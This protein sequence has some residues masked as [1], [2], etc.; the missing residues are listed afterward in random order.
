MPFWSWDIGGAYFFYVQ[1]YGI[2]SAKGAAAVSGF[3]AANPV[4]M[5]ADK[6]DRKGQCKCDEDYFVSGAAARAGFGIF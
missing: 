2:Q 5:G 3:A 4:F 1:V 6:G